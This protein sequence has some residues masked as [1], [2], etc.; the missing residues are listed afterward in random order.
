MKDVFGHEAG[1]R[2]VFGSR[3]CK[4]MRV[5]ADTHVCELLKASGVNILGRSS[6]P[7]YSMAGTTE[8]ALHGNTSTP[9]KQGYSAGGS[10]GGAMAA[11]VAGIVPIAHGTDIAGSIRIPASYCG[12]VGL[13]P[14]RGRVSYGPMLDENGFG[15]GQNFVQTK[16]VRDA[17]AMLDCLSVPQPGDPFFIPKPV[18][19]YAVLAR[20]KPPRLRIGW[21][22]RGLMGLATDR[23]VGEAVAQI[24]ALLADM[25]HEVVEESPESIGLEAMSSMANIWF[26]GFHLRLDGF[27]KRTGHPIGPQ[28]LEPV[29]LAIY[30]YARRM[31]P[32]QFLDAGVV[33]NAVRRK[34]GRYFAR[35]DAWLSPTTTRA[36]EPWGNYNLGRNDVS[37]DDVAEKILRPVCQFTLPHNIMGTPAI[38]LPLAVNSAG[39][40]IGI[41]IGLKPA[42]EHVLLQLAAALEEARPW[43]A[44]VPPLHV[45]HI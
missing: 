6:A 15:L 39:L 41:Q 31:T 5:T 32:A 18:E 12:G 14:S 29:T 25:G 20:Q 40:P 16:T 22:T 8:S 36:A 3:L 13:K 37:M 28:T 33:L 42:Q 34:L 44:R 1:R 24:A 45:S 23:E 17:A 38:S 11:V 43:V 9:W 10:S 27:S 30:E 35:Y 26:F 7:E 4:D 2:I 19:S 21:S